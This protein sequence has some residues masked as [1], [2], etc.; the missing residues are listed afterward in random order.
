[1]FFKGT[2]STD[3]LKKCNKLLQY[4][5]ERANVK[6]ARQQEKKTTTKNIC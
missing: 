1:M 2:I 5:L 4:F 6:K 3:P